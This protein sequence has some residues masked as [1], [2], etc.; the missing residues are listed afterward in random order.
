VGG[1]ALIASCIKK[2]LIDEYI[3]TVLPVILGH[4][5][6]LFPSPVAEEWLSM[7]DCRTYD[8]GILQLHYRR[9]TSENTP[10]H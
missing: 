2:R 3:L 7:V 5:L 8:R 6:R 10:P 4:G 9:F 1:S